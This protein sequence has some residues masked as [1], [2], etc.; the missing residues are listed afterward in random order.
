MDGRD[1]GKGPRALHEAYVRLFGCEDGRTVLADLER[2]GFGGTCCFA[3]DP[4]RTAFNEGRRSLYLHL[5]HMLDA[6]NFPVAAGD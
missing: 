6:A 1:N 3:G 4:C 2:R 5:R